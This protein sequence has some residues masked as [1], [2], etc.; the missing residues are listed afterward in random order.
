MNKLTLVEPI[1]LSG[2]IYPNGFAI[3]Q[4]TSNR[5][6]THIFPPSI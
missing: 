3:G 2:K 5:Q 4:L 6:L 1:V